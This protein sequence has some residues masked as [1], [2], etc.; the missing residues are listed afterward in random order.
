MK[1]LFFVLFFFALFSEEVNIFLND[2]TYQNGVIFTNKGGVIQTEDI[3]IQAE[4]IQYFHRLEDGKW[5][6]KVE[7]ENDLL[8]Q[9]KG[10]VFVGSE[11]LFDF[12]TMT[13]TVYDGKTYSSMWYIGGDQIDLSKDG[14]YKATN[15]F[16]TTCENKNSSWDLRASKVSVFKNELFQAKKVRLRFLQWP[17]LWLPSF[18]LNLKRFKEPIFRY[19]INWNKGPKV[20]FRYQ[21]YSW[22][23]LAFYARLEY[24]F[25]KGFGGALESEYAPIGEKT[26]FMTRNY[27]GKDRLFNAE[28]VEKRYRV[29][30]AFH[31]ESQNEKTKTVITWDKYS[32]VRMP[33]DFKSDD[34]EVNSA[35][36]TQVWVRRKED[37]L[38]TS[39]KVTPRVN[40]FESLK[41][42]LPTLYMKSLPIELGKSQLF[43]SHLFRASY[44]DFDYS[45]QLTQSL[46][47][48]QS[49]RLELYEKLYR[50]FS[51]SALK[52]TP[53]IN[54]RGIFYSTSPSHE[55][56]WLGI[57][58]GKVLANFRGQKT[59]EGF[60]HVVEPYLLYEGLTKPTVSSDQH[61]IFSIQDGYEKLQQINV[62]FK[63]F[64]FSSTRKSLFSQ[65][66]AD[67][68]LN[69]FFSDP[70]IP[71]V[72][73]RGYL[74]LNFHLPNMDLSLDHAYNFRHHT[75]D[76]SNARLKWTVSENTALCFE[77]RYRSKYYWRKSDPE[78]FILDVTRSE[79]DLLL[80][81]LSDQRITLLSNFFVRLNPFWEMKFESHHGFH[82][83]GEKPYNEFRIHLYTSLSAA[84]KLHFYYGYTLNNHFDWN[85]S[86]KLV[87]KSF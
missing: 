32:D 49:I 18:K 19:Y 44:L 72:V 73:P 51:I 24:R 45:D 40:S 53:E 22:Q 21:L 1:L 52:I 6:Q 48:F 23:E 54:A 38:L 79:Q 8:I 35:L 63:N 78:N 11:L 39:L 13:G 80:S 41:Q 34:F 14:S 76:L 28:D 17:K 65:I 4:S 47:D 10:R 81:P 66:N 84:W 67:L 83:L 25:R 60:R 16:V 20:G 37:S 87:K 9:Y 36:K 29:Q 56:K 74:L 59:Y 82:R 50:P 2:P 31:S 77:A 64:F 33:G 75:L 42:E 15:A 55:N 71:Q 5:I 85:V 69:A 86:I 12:Q 26:S 61:Y 27:L 58:G 70:V 7:A 68:Y 57:L 30:G 43:F 3:R 46:T 62:G